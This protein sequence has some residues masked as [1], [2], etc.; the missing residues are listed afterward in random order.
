MASPTPTRFEAR[1]PATF[2]A[3]YRVR[4][5]QSPEKPAATHPVPPTGKNGTE[6][7]KRESKKEGRIL[8]PCSIESGAREQECWPVQSE[9]TCPLDRSANW[10]AVFPPNEFTYAYADSS[11]GYRSPLWSSRLVLF[12]RTGLRFCLRFS[13]SLSLFLSFILIHP[14]WEH[15]FNFR[16]EP[17]TYFIYLSLRPP[18]SYI[19]DMIFSTR[20]VAPV[21]HAKIFCRRFYSLLVENNRNN[22]KIFAVL[23]SS[24]NF[25]R[26]IS[27][28]WKICA[29][30]YCVANKT[31]A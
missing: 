17:S 21:L 2:R 8:F 15:E 23:S 11:L 12:L 28:H 31:S 9:F 3:R 22:I 10:I 7:G 19:R 27:F 16:R 4:R 20:Q 6:R 25:F 26:I 13:F 24:I 18:Q 5:G 1:Q 14:F 29:S 30:K